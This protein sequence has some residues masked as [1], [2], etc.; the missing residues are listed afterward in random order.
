MTTNRGKN[1]TKFKMMQLLSLHCSEIEWKKCANICRGK[2]QD[3][4]KSPLRR[5]KTNANSKKD[6]LIPSKSFFQ[7][8][9]QHK[10]QMRDTQYRIIFMTKLYWDRCGFGL[11]MFMPLQSRKIIIYADLLIQRAWQRNHLSLSSLT[12]SSSYQKQKRAKII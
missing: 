1:N 11:K 7:R 10:K 5:T 3:S 9:Q 12:L 6:L 2:H 4:I 8:I